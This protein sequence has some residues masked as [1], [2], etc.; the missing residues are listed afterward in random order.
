MSSSYNKVLLLGNL[1]RDPE[2]RQM[3]NSGAH[4]CSFSIATSRTYKRQDGT[5]QKE[6]TFVDVSAFGRQGEVIYQYLKKGRPVFVEGRLR[7][8]QWETSTG[9]RRS[10]LSVI[11]ESFQF[12]GGRQDE[13]DGHFSEDAPMESSRK[14]QA[15]SIDPSTYG[16]ERTEDV[17]F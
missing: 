1:T 10:K 14:A 7:L 5:Q 16:S 6:T 9:D 15:P 13:E 2:L 3:G 8:E 12:V 4:V 17:P 11:L